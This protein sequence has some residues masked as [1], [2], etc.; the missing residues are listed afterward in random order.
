MHE[1]SIAN[2]VLEAVRAEAAR[3]PGARVVKVGVKVGALAGVDPEA[4]SFC[5]ESLVPGSDLNP[6]ELDIEFVP[7]QQRCSRCG[8]A[9]TV[10]DYDVACPACGTSDTECIAGDE[11]KLTYLEV[12][13]P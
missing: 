3:Y 9:F 13:E 12:E 5:F 11:L 4:L 1:L 7:R 6:L 2:S 8:Q 10:A